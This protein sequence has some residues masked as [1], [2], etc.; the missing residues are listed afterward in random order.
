M[1]FIKK[2]DM[3][4][5]LLAG[6]QGSRLG[7]LTKDVAKPAVPFGGKYRIIDFALSNCTNSDI[8]TVGVLTQYQPMELNAYIGNGQPWDFDRMYG[9]V[10]VLPPYVKGKAG[11][12][13][14]GTANSIFQNIPFIDQFDPNYVIVL[15]GDHIYKMNYRWMLDH[16]LKKDADCTIAVIEVPIEEAS[17]F[18]VMSTDQNLKITE[19]QEKPEKPKSNLASMGVYIFNWPK[20]KEYLIKDEATPNSSNDF[21]KDVIPA[22]LKNNERLYAYKYLGYWKDVGTLQSF[23]EANMDL[24]KEDVSLELYDPRWKIYARNANAPPQYIGKDAHLDTVHI[25]EGCMI[26]G[27]ITNSIIF[28]K[29]TVQK[30][31]TISNSVIMSGAK[32]EKGV[33]LNYTIVAEGAVIGENTVIGKPATTKKI[34]SISIVAKD[35]V[36]RPEAI[37]KSGSVVSEDM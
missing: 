36:I 30:G 32:I 33:D 2:K 35:V 17:R 6:G 37:I 12:W 3:I 18:G 21:G 26:E 31:A 7:V 15:S 10:S 23:W 5:M 27:S 4:A 13:Y 29:V 14:K 19:F 16:H 34:P 8:D 28:P 1:S 22:M 20:L 24:L 25:S 11:E 9:G